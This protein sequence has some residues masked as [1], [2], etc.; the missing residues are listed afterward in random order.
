MFDLYYDYYFYLPPRTNDMIVPRR[1]ASGGCELMRTISARSVID[2][3]CY[4]FHFF[5]IPFF[6]FQF[7]TPS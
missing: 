6:L 5:F 3:Y 7:S 1:Y 4:Y 2:F